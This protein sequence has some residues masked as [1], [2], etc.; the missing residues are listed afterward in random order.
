MA[1]RN[2]KMKEAEGEISKELARQVSHKS[3]SP[4]A[5]RAK[6]R[7]THAEEQL[8]DARDSGKKSQK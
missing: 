5:E 6:E 3:G 4:A 8:A 1:E 7:R 2:R